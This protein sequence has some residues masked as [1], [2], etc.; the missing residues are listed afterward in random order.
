MTPLRA[1]R[2]VAIA[3]LAW[4]AWLVAA[5]AGA[6]EV[7]GTVLDAGGKPIEYATVSVPELRRGTAADEQG[8]FALD[9][10]AGRHVLQVAQLG[11]QSAH[12]TVDV[13]AAPVQVNVT[14]KNEPIPLAE[15]AVTASAFG[16]TGKGEGATLRRMDV[17]TT[18]GGAADVFQSLR[19]LPGI[20]AP[21][22]GA[23]IYT[24]GG[25]P[26]ET[27]IRL[28][29]GDLGHPYH[30]EN[31]SGGLFS[32]IETYMLRSAFF[33]SGGFSSKY[34]GVM[35]GVLD[36]ET[37]D[38]LN[39]RTVSASANLA[40]LGA[41][42][43]WAIVPDR[44]SFIGSTRY[45]DPSL[46][47]KLY[48]S[49]REYEQDPRGEDAAAKLLW[50]YSRTGRA[51]LLYLDSGDR[52]DMF[53]NFLN[54]KE[55]Y[56][57]RA[58]NQ[59]GALQ[60]SDAIGA[61]LAIRGQVSGQFWKRD[62]ELA[63][64]GGSSSERN[65][66]ANVDAT[67]SASSG[68]ELSFGANLRRRAAE[69]D[70]EVP[71]DSTDY[72]PG[73]PTRT[74]SSRPLLDAP[75]FYLEDKL[76]VFGP[77]YAT[78]GG[79]V[80]YASNAPVWTVDPRASLAWRVDDR[81][82]V[83]LAAG[84]YHQPPL[85]EY[86]DPSYGNPTLGPMRADHLIAGYEWL[87]EHTNIR[88]EIYDKRYRDL[89]TNDSL[90]Y[91][92][93]GG[94]GYARGVDVFAKGNVKWLSGWV[95]YGY[96]DSRRMEFSNPRE[97]PASYGVRHSITLVSTYQYNSAWSL[98]ARYSASS[99]RPYTPIVGGT[100][101]PARDIWHPIQAEDNSGLMPAYNR[102]DV[103]L[104][105]L[106]SMPAGLGFPASG[107]CVAY[108]EALNVLGI[109]NELDY[110]YNFDYSQR[111]PESSYFDRRMLVFGVGLSW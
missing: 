108:C 19:T 83:R 58:R 42:T 3:G 107:V 72:A 21:A 13:A 57:N 69:I 47:F 103:R 44:L 59:L 67:W 91:Y 71:A 77:V 92:A 53:V 17:Y 48:G 84:R 54:Y 99:G 49:S 73:A 68:H 5:P 95:S 29:G 111:S 85:P 50:R 78:L 16:K 26:D 37:Q 86:Q 1:P 79:R 98:G 15:V 109:A 10:P 80:D 20:N 96:L 101:D 62:W 11:Y 12:V 94:H 40:G 70:K 106:F 56:S 64:F 32:S 2:R 36:M 89:I 100:Y 97:V 76:R 31:A 41:S 60:F 51:A 88:V 66:Q 93:N 23:A 81:Q 75:G 9:L 55:P 65:A 46:L 61:T 34:G 35:S 7:R 74:Y 27:L 30:Y 28:D 90:S 33:S 87:S 45:S 25:P 24:R 104:T 14:L 110:T 39:L 8:R 22:E 18:P 6:A 105:R 38:P 52:T 63:Q 43:S 102:L 82:I 4:F